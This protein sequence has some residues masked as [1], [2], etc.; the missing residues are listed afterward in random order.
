MLCLRLH[1]LPLLPPCQDANAVED[2][3]VAAERARVASGG[4]DGDVLVVRVRSGPRPALP[5]PPVV[6]PLWSPRHFR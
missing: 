4:A 1:P 2:T 3:D 5:S 6:L